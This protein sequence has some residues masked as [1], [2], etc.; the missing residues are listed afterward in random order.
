MMGVNMLANKMANIVPAGHT[1]YTPINDD[2]API[3]APYTQRPTACF[4]AVTGSV[5]KKN[6]PNKKLP[7]N[8]ACKGSAAFDTPARNNA[9]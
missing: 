3:N 7:A 1:E 5:A 4:E 9:P 8:I 2:I 6:T